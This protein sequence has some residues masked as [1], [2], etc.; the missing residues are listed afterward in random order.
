MIYFII[1]IVIALIIAYFYWGDELFDNISTFL[2]AI[3]CGIIICVLGGFALL[4][5]WAIIQAL[6]S[7]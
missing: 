5:I 7:F 2:F 6:D 4:G 3:L 1:I